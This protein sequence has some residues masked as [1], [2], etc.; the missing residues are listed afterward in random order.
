VRFFVLSKLAELY[1]NQAIKSFG[2]ALR[3]S[4]RFNEDYASLVELE[5]VEKPEDMAEV[6]KRFLRR[7]AS[8]A[9][10]YERSGKVPFIPSESDLDEIIRLTE[11]VGVGMVS[12]ALVSHALTKGSE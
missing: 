6:L 4:I 11:Q 7:Y 1:E 9:R 5:Y 3:V 8:Q 10:R 12:S 2:K